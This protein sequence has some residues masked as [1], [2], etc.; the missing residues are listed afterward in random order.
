VIDEMRRDTKK[1]GS[2]GNCLILANQIVRIV[3][4]QNN[5]IKPMMVAMEKPTLS[6]LSLDMVA[7]SIL[8]NLI[9]KQD[10]YSVMD[11]EGY[12]NMNL[13]HLGEFTSLFFKNFS[14]VDLMPLMTYILNRMK[15]GDNYYEV[16]LLSNILTHMFGFKDLE[17]NILNEKQLNSLAGGI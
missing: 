4:N 13:N 17:I 7:F 6:D 15:V 5:W 16:F 1:L 11:S 2:S 10:E 9:E 3:R 12:L 8:R 14:H